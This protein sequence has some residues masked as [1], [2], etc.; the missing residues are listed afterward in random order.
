MA[1]IIPIRRCNLSCK[2]CN[3]YD[4]YSKPVPDRGDAPADQQTGRPGYRDRHFERRRAAA[5]PGTGRDYRGHAPANVIAGMITNGYLLTP[6]R[7]RRLNRAGLDHMQIS[8]DNVMPDDVSKKSLKVLDKKLQML[9]GARAVP[10]QHQLGGGRRHQASGRRADREPARCRVGLQFDGGHH[11]RRRRP[12]AAARRARAGSV[13]PVMKL[14]K[15]HFSRLNYFQDSI[16]DGRPETGNAGRVR[17]ICISAKT[18][19]STT[20]RSSAVIRRSRWKSTRWRTSGGSTSRRNRAPRTAPFRACT[21]CRIS[22]SGAASRPS[23]RPARGPV[24]ETQPQL[25]QIQSSKRA[26]NSFPAGP[27]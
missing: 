21:T 9:S 1:H 19:W 14:E 3:E 4:D 26:E 23:K 6:D 25:V 10:R 12:V 7:I 8:I 2:Y 5:A 18:D 17:A 27:R 15:R 11:P 22:I 16:A 20:V 13:P 24:E